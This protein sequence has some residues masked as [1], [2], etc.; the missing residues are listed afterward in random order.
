ML[1]IKNLHVLFHNPMYICGVNHD[2]EVPVYCMYLQSIL[3]VRLALWSWE[4]ESCQVKQVEMDASTR[5]SITRFFQAR[6]CGSL[7]TGRW[8][9]S[10]VRNGFNEIL[11]QLH[12][13]ISYGSRVTGH[14]FV[15]MQVE[16]NASKT[17]GHSFW[18]FWIMVDSPDCRSEVFQI[19]DN[20]FRVVQCVNNI[21]YNIFF[22]L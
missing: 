13:E 14:S 11:W 1:D 7:L 6:G 20:A 19:I 21:V 8:E 15:Q 9:W 10:R 5:I 12:G 18:R 17:I 16:K 22:F 3:T 4:A 2:L